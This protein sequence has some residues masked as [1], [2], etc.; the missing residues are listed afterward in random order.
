MGW[1]W[2]D[3]DREFRQQ[4]AANP[5]LHQWV[6]V[7]PSLLATTQINRH[8]STVLP[9]S[10]CS[11]CRKADHY[12]GECVLQVFERPQPAATPHRQ[13]EQHQTYTTVTMAPDGMKN[14]DICHR[15]NKGLC[16]NAVS[17]KYTAMRAASAQ[18]QC[19]RVPIR[20]GLS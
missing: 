13:P 16:M 12:T 18:P 8:P 6:E 10:W 11:L 2:L 3:Y 17:C 1:G 19:N 20:A 15:Y 4:V 14:R 9:G 7:N 5:A